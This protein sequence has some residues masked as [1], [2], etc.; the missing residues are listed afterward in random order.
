LNVV[1]PISTTK[2]LSLTAGGDLMIYNDVRAYAGDLLLSAGGL[3]G[4]DAQ[5]AA[6]DGGGGLY[7][8]AMSGNTV[9]FRGGGIDPFSAANVSVIGQQVMIE[10]V[11]GAQFNVDIAAGGNIS[12]GAGGYVDAGNNAALTTIFGDI[13]L[14]DGAQVLATNHVYLDLYGGASRVILNGKPDNPSPST[15]LAAYA[16]GPGKVNVAF[17][18]RGSG[19]IVIDGIET[20]TTLDGGSGFFVDGKPALVGFGLNLFYGLAIYTY[21]SPAVT[22]LVQAFGDGSAACHFRGTCSGVYTPDAYAAVTTE[23][24][25]TLF[26]GQTTGGGENQFGGTQGLAEQQPQLQFRRTGTRKV[27]RCT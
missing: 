24:S 12:I 17:L 19:G 7:N 26:G 4:V 18:N 11:V 14:E 13:V 15:I 10:N 9:H 22:A 1:A 3:L 23:Q 20:D 27:G 6:N 21:E 2:Q 5:L 25:L 8:I 16:G